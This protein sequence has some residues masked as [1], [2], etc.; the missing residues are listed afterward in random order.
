MK[1]TTKPAIAFILGLIIVLIYPTDVTFIFIGMILIAIGII[2][3]AWITIQPPKLKKH[4]PR[5]S[6]RETLNQIKKAVKK[7]R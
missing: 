7:R 6:R 4:A 1:N 2:D 3:L 5:E